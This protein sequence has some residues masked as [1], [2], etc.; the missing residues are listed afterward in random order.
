MKKLK[1][2][3]CVGLLL[4]LTACQ[5]GTGN[6]ADSN[7]AAEQKIAISSEAAISTMEP[8]TAGDTTSTLVM[9]Q[10][11][12][13]L[14]V[15]G[16]EDEL[17]LG[18]AAEEPAISEDETVYT[19]KIRE[20]AKWSND[21][22]VTANDFVYAW[23]QVASPKSGSIHQA[24]FF[25]V[26]K[27][28]KEIALEG[29]DVNTLGVKA[30]DDKTL[31]ITLERPTPYLKS[32]LSFPV[33]FPQNEKY[34]K[35][36][37]D[38]YAT[39][40]EHLIY[41]GPFKLKEWDNASS[42][43]WT[44]EKNDTYWDAEKVKLSEAKVSVIKSP[45]TAVN[46]FD[47]N[48]LD[49]VNKLSGEF[50]PGYVDNPAFLS[51]PQF[52]TYFL[53]MNSVRDGK[54]NP[55]LA[56]NNIRKA[57][58]QAF[59]KESFVKEVLQDQSTATD[60]VIPPGQTIAPDGTDFTKLAAKKNNYLT[61]DTAKAKE[62]WEKGKKEIGLDKIKLEFFQFQLEENLDG[63]EVN[64]TQVPFTI[65]V[66]RDQTRDYD[67]EL[68]G[69]GTDYRDPLTVMR[70]FTSDSTLGGVTF[71]SD[72]YD[73]LIQETR[74]THAAD[75]EARLND[76]A[77]AQDILVN[78]ET[79]LAPIYNRSISVLANQKIKDLYWHSFGPTYSLKWAYV[80]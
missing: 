29:A 24:L 72:T 46:L 64:V 48:E 80:N 10:V 31:E 20:D 44:Y 54:E 43:D 49:V 74:T 33:L 42:D 76:F 28:A 63:L 15:L 32:L 30:L 50:I 65:R 67:L 39:D 77:Q 18:V 36:Q 4:A 16:K 73:Q 71:K 5:A 11:Y 27:N 38:K 2:L 47:S 45:T 7:K 9:N 68:S 55:A 78:Q 21:D 14:Y 57:L 8:H 40:A 59:D 17:E 79:V 56:N 61:Y 66:D 51:I 58:A 12:E 70:I 22:P 52:V 75:Q 3:G 34:I 25:D 13:G 53:K 19:F 6:S 23:Q 26:I 69:W 1:M 60:Q 41:N 35:E 62:F 37:G